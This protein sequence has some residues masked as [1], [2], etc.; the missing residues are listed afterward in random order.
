MD[1]HSANWLV[2]DSE[3]EKAWNDHASVWLSNVLGKNFSVRLRLPSEKM[4]RDCWMNNL[5]LQEG[6]SDVENAGRR[7]GIDI[8]D[9]GGN[10]LLKLKMPLPFDGVFVTIEK[11][12]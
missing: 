8:F 12:T 1:N 2:F 4:A 3:S 10:L 5:T 6:V 7:C 11:R 9:D